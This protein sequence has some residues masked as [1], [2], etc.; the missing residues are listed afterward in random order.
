MRSLFTLLGER[1]LHFELN[2]NISAN[3]PF[4]TEPAALLAIK[5]NIRV[6][7]VI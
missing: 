3:T 7:D 6:G 2:R 5:G 1:L 4:A